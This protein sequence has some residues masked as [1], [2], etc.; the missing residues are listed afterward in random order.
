[1][2]RVGIH[3]RIGMVHVNLFVKRMWIGSSC[4]NRHCVSVVR[5]V[6]IVDATWN[7]IR[8]IASMR[9]VQFV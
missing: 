3:V 1:M 7:K 2:F 6:L 9:F 8:R 5:M 4:I